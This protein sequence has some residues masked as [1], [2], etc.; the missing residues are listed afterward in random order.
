MASELTEELADNQEMLQSYREQQKQDDIDLSKSC[1][2]LYIC[3]QPYRVQQLRDL[4]K[5]KKSLEEGKLSND[6]Q[7]LSSKLQ[8]AFQCM[9]VLLAEEPEHVGHLIPAILAV[10][11][12]ICVHGTSAPEPPYW[13]EMAK[14][15]LAFQREIVQWLMPDGEFYNI[16]TVNLHMEELIAVR[17]VIDRNKARISHMLA[18]LA[19]SISAG[20]AKIK[21]LSTAKKVEGVKVDKSAKKANRPGTTQAYN[22]IKRITDNQKKLAAKFAK[23]RGEHISFESDH[24]YSIDWAKLYIFSLHGLEQ[25]QKEK[26]P[27]RKSAHM[28]TVKHDDSTSSD[29]IDYDRKSEELRD[30]IIASMKKTLEEGAKMYVVDNPQGKPDWVASYH[31]VERLA[32]DMGRKVPTKKPDWM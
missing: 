10:E 26:K 19:D 1:S 8:E 27:F 28:H 7:N 22:N 21:T 4:G 17:F 30:D 15:T 2:E 12:R 29:G 25:D 5:Q 14:P 9:H 20:E 13:L 18:E 24:K 3:T 23:Y 32:R 16:S 31:E 6:F 11:Q